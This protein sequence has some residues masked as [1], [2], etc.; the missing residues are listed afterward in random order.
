M[1]L[2]IISFSLQREDNYNKMK[3]YTLNYK[4]TVYWW[5]H[6]FWI[7]LLWLI[8]TQ[9]T[10]ASPIPFSSH[11]TISTSLKSALVQNDNSF[12]Q[13]SDQQKIASG[14]KSVPLTFETSD[15]D[16]IFGGSI[17]SEIDAENAAKNKD[18][19]VKP[20]TKNETIINS[21]KPKLT[22]IKLDKNITI[23]DT[24]T[25]EDLVKSLSLSN[26]NST[27]ATATTMLTSVTEPNAMSR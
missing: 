7:T 18:W 10:N 11:E 25:D 20:S 15:T 13:T 8:F 17:G 26:V 21:E 14:S 12:Q 4:M 16:D 2:Q 3:R 9:S 27:N 22:S 19:L 23:P 1:R 24:D 5:T 6:W